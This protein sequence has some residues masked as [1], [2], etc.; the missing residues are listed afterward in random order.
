M[1]KNDCRCSTK[2]YHLESIRK[3]KRW[4]TSSKFELQFQNVRISRIGTFQ[5]IP[6][7]DVGQV[8]D[9]IALRSQISL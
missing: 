4:P 7:S 6:N 3:P 2:N 9:T 8:F 5:N 1:G